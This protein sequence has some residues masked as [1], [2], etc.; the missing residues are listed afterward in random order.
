MDLAYDIEDGSG[1]VKMW[2]ESPFQEESWEV[3]SKVWSK[4][5]WAFDGDIVRR[6]NEWRRSRG[7]GGLR[8][9]SDGPAGNVV[10]EVG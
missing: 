3:G 8:M 2:G 6:T 4:W 1:G 10:G 9:G 5:W 7:L